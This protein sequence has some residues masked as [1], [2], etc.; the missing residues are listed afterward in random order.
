MFVVIGSCRR[1]VSGSVVAGSRCRIAFGSSHGLVASVSLLCRGVALSSVSVTLLCRVA[2]LENA[3]CC[4]G[5]KMILA[6][7]LCR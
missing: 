3:V 6:L 2:G 5:A 4:R 7:I 1:M